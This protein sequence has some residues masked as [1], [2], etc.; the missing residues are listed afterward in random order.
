MLVKLTWFKRRGSNSESGKRTLSQT[1]GDN[2]SSNDQSFTNSNPWKS[3]K[4]GAA[5]KS[6]SYDVTHDHYQTMQSS[7]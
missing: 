5:D 2:D 3:S 4:T 1:N 7:D 6:V